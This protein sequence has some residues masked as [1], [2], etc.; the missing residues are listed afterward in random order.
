[1]KLRDFPT[2]LFYF[3]KMVKCFAILLLFA[4]LLAPASATPSSTAT[5]DEVHN[6]IKKAAK[7]TRAGNL[8]EAEALLRQAADLDTN[9]T[10]AKI[11]LAYVLVKER[12]LRDAY[13]ICIPVIENDR[14]NSHAYAVAGMM[15]LAG[16][17]FVEARKF[18]A[19]AITL[20]R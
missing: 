3:P 5:S 4:F 18:L 13:D 20:N 7:L 9:R 15:L 8:S 1:M 17:H 10:E 14:G 2:D 11:E 6:L 16:G 12:R 19:S